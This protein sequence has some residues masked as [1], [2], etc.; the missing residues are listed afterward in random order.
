MRQLSSAED[1][2]L[3][4]DVGLCY[5]QLV[6]AAAGKQGQWPGDRD[7]GGISL[8]GQTAFKLRR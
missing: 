3:E 5:E 8:S 7:L 4:K 2:P 1:N 6:P